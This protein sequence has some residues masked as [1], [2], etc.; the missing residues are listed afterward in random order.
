MYQR[1][2]APSIPGSASQLNC[3]ENWKTS[4]ESLFVFCLPGFKHEAAA[5]YKFLNLTFL[6][7]ETMKSALST[8]Q[9]I[10]KIDTIPYFATRGSFDWTNTLIIIKSKLSFLITLNW[11]ILFLMTRGT[12]AP[13]HFHLHWEEKQNIFFLLFY[14]ALFLAH[15]SS[16]MLITQN[17]FSSDWLFFYPSI[18]TTY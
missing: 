6:W 4:R 9:A 14:W 5:V 16:N 1:K 13:Y 11:A 15:I 3:F 12:K 10:C 7:W 17:Y 8:F 2:D 18:G